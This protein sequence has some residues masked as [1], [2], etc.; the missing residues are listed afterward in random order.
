MN[1]FRNLS[2]LIL[3]A[4][5]LF[6]CEKKLTDLQPIDQIPGEKAISSMND[7]TT[8]VNGVYATWSARRSVYISSFISDEIRLGTGSEYRN[9]GNALFNWQFV[10]D[11]QDW[12]DGET[13]GVWTNLYAV[14]DR[15]NRV[16]ELMVPVPTANSTEAAL[17]N[18]FRGEMLAARALAHLELLRCY[19]ITAEYNPTSLGVVLQTTYVK[20]PATYRPNRSTQAQVMASIDSDLAAAR[21]LIPTSFFTISRITLNA[22][23]AGQARA[24]MHV[25]NWQGVIDR[26]TEVINLQP[27]TT[28]ANYPA[29]WTT[30]TLGEN[31][32]TEVIW[33]LNVTAA[34]LGNAVGTLW[35]DVSAVG[36]VQASPSAKLMGTFNSA[37]DV[38]FS[39]FFR[40]V[41]RNLIAK[42][43]V[44]P[45]AG[46]NFQFD[47]KMMRTSELILARAEAYAELSQTLNANNDLSSL[48]TNRITGYV[49]TSIPLKADLIDAIYLERY[50]E[51]C[52]EGQRYFD[53]RRRSLPITR[54]ISD[55]G[56]IPSSQTLTVNDFRYILPIPNQEKQAN[57][58]I[59]QNTGY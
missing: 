46:E 2:C 9:V 57:P 23:I 35:Q 14:I 48:R 12:R 31:Q 51:L 19:S 50:K 38:R 8:A 39:T 10:S 53:L 18:Q 47:I 40:I 34:N 27:L 29:I 13:G 59:E 45:P 11:S 15:A 26:T 7:L 20:T 16:L 33:K 6:S 17:K 37:T 42:Y 24:A 21:T 56:G 54:D 55:I 5:S 22:V 43:G 32:T 58:N 52:Y 3:V 41:P 25:K 4:F 36:Q 49:H 30:R 1:L 28:I 44:N